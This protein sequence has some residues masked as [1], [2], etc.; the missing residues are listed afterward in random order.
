MSYAVKEIFKSLQGEGANLGRVAIFVRFAGC[1][2]WSGQ[3]EDRGNGLL[4]C[5]AWCDTEFVGTDGGHGG[6]YEAHRLAAKC[7]ELWKTERKNR[8]V[9]LTGGEPTL[10]VDSLLVDT[11][12]RWEFEVAIETNGTRPCPNGI[13][14]ITVSPKAG[15]DLVQLT[16]HE[17]KLVYPQPGAEPVRYRELPF[18]RFYLQPLWVDDETQRQKHVEETVRYCMEHPQWQLSIQSHKV[19]GIQ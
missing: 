4:A 2:G 7:S 15:L 1:N 5:S 3:A 13:D 19:V 17:L 9:I 8:L 18:S 10:Q 12:R 6:R 14:W 11:L 16:G